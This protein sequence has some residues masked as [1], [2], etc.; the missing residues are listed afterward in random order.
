MFEILFVRQQVQTW[1][2]RETLSVCAHTHTHTH[3]HTRARARV[4]VC[5]CMRNF[6]LT[7]SVCKQMYS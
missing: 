3:T 1:P 4:C 7:Q 2:Q 6:T 5:V